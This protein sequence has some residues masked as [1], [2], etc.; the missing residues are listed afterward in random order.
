MI[1]R[2]TALA[3]L[4]RFENPKVT[5]GFPQFRRLA[6]VRR[7]CRSQAYGFLRCLLWR[8]PLVWRPLVMD[9]FVH[10]LAL[11]RPAL[12]HPAVP[13]QPCTTQEMRLPRAVCGRPIAAGARRELPTRR[14]RPGTQ[15]C[16]PQDIATPLGPDAGRFRECMR[17][18]AHR[19]TSALPS[20]LCRIGGWRHARSD[21]GPRSH[22]V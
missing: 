9:S 13:P 14:P 16:F 21:T 18:R 8:L 19:P 11:I 5:E 20:R 3:Y 22:R 1:T 2:A 6:R 15:P 7:R 17:D 4:P 12:I 10:G